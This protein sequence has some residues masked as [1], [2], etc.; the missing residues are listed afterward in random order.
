MTHLRF[1]LVV[2]LLPLACRPAAPPPERTG[3][4]IAAP[5]EAVA[6]R[7]FPAVGLAVLDT[8]N[9]W[10]AA[11]P[12]S[13]PVLAPGMRVTI[14]F[15][16]S[17]AVPAWG[18][19]VTRHRDAECPA[20]FAQSRWI[21]YRAYD[22]ALVDPPRPEAIDVPSATLA[23]AGEAAWVRGAD[24]RVRADLDGD[25]AAEEARVCRAGEGHHFT[26]WSGSGGE[27]RRRAHEYYDWGA[28]V[29]PTCSPEESAADESMVAPD[30]GAR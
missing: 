27:R 18:A 26:L 1:A 6:S 23:V 25:G 11:F 13:A 24:G 22:L 17:T 8:A 3:D 2:A 28:F 12:D 15:A 10:C 30:S 21:D 14:V 7:S 19:T 5:R 29:D 9:R 16:E 4:S 20:D